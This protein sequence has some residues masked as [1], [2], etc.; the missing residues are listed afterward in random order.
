MRV[1]RELG[2]EGVVDMC[3]SLVIDSSKEHTYTCGEKP[4]ALF[5]GRAF[6]V[7]KTRIGPSELGIGKYAIIDH[8]LPTHTIL[9]NM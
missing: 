6:R 9:I 3:I 4:V 8:A 5:L 7:V 1:R 2:F